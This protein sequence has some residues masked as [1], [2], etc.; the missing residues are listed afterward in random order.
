MLQLK[1]YKNI[2]CVEIGSFKKLRQIL[3]V[4]PTKLRIPSILKINFEKQSL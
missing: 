3:C 4:I 2:F 1:I